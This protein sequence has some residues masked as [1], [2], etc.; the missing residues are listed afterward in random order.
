MLCFVN[1]T[2]IETYMKMY[3]EFSYPINQ[4]AQG[5]MLDK[6]K[7]QKH[8]QGRLKK[9]SKTGNVF[10]EKYFILEQDLHYCKYNMRS[11][12]TISQFAN[13]H[14]AYCWTF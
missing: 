3:G 9:K 1:L 13:V 6:K 11:K 2:Q 12:Y 14:I 7:M 10:T 4:M 5:W 8:K